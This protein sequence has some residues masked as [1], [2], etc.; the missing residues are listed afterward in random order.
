MDD[1]DEE[2][3]ENVYD[4]MC[5]N[6][7][8]ERGLT[9]ADELHEGVL[10]WMMLKDINTLIENSKPGIPEA[11]QRMENYYVEMDILQ[12]VLQKKLEDNFGKIEDT[13]EFKTAQRSRD[14]TKIKEMSYKVMDKVNYENY[15]TN[16]EQK[17]SQRGQ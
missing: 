10:Y 16:G 5:D 11:A 4:F 14:D 17:R 8:D 7:L 13:D 9:T 3:W 15:E 2:Y 12:K 6:W 1:D